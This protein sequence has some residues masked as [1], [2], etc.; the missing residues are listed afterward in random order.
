[1]A[2]C[3]LPGVA[4]DL[5]C[6]RV[7]RRISSNSDEFSTASNGSTI[8]L[9]RN[10][11]VIPMD[12]THL[13]AIR[14]ASSEAAR[15]HAGHYRKDGVTPYIVHPARVASLVA[16]FGGNH[17]AILSA[18]LHDVFE[19]CD[20]ETCSLAKDTI[21]TLPLPLD[22]IQKIHTITAALTK[23]PALLKDARI[24]DSLARILHAP[25]EA[26]LVK[27][28]DRIDNLIDADFRD[29]EFRIFYYQKS[30]LIADT[31]R[32]AALSAGYREAIDTLDRILDSG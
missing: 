15:A 6:D 10:G 20:A 28:C 30:N 7:I 22:D 13:T 21:D 18:W 31:L 2:Q 16:H 9:N 32:A 25:P 4:P 23:N 5:P 8:Q 17:I 3:D 27:I 19:D 26:V 24:P 1:M 12:L 14:L 29:E 11:Q